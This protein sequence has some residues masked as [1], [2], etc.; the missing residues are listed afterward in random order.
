MARVLALSAVFFCL[1]SPAFPCSLCSGQ[2]SKTLRED[3]ALAKL[4]VY[5]TL[6]DSNLTVDRDGLASGTTKLKIETILRSNPFL[7]GRTIL[8]LPRYVP[9][10]P[11]NPARFMIFC[12]VCN[13]RL[14]PYR[15]IP[16][17]SG[18]LVNYIA[19]A[20]TLD[21]RESTHLLCYFFRYLDHP[22]PA[23]ADDAFLE[24][25]KAGDSEIGRLAGKLDARK[26]RAWVHDSRTPATR[27]NLFGFLLGAC[28]ETSD[29]GAMRSL[30]VNPS[31]NSRDALSGLL[32][33]Y[34]CLC[35][36]EGWELA[37]TLLSDPHQPFAKR[38]AVLGTLRFFHGWQPV[39]S[40]SAVLRGLSELVAQADI[41]DLAIEDLR[42]W[43]LW[44]L[45]DEVLAQFG[46]QS[47]AAPIMRRAIVRYAL[48]CPKS[49]AKAFIAAHR[50]TD[51]ALVADVEE[52]LQFEKDTR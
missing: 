9:V 29:A 44:E 8:E 2:R 19:G 17:Q 20:L 47:H 39:E 22:D 35:P 11:K 48:C 33:G 31:D 18:D 36:R 16:V 25:A 15:G 34:I 38:S 27:L 50:T 46:K 45:T 32:S 4:I 49:G 12:D 10:D 7:A 13:G 1:S 52:S 30:I 26:L 37:W 21:S 5:G 41:A 43:Q 14:D 42:R 40:R 24:F 28:G 51:V 3:A 6:T 23:I